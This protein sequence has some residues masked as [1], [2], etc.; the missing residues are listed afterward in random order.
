MS[1]AWEIAREGDVVVL[2]PACAAFDRFKNFM[3]RDELL[4]KGIQACHGSG[5]TGTNRIVVVFY[6]IQ[7]PHQLDTVFHSDKPLGHCP[8]TLSP[9][10]AV[11]TNLSP[12]HLDYHHTMEEYTQAK[13]NIFP[14]PARYGVP[15]R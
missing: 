12:N 5:G 13:L 6:P 10:V 14:A 11:F 4:L 9:S 15:L 8:D 1:A 3:E 2:S 7:L